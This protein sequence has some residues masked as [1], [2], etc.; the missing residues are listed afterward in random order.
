MTVRILRDIEEAISRE[1]RRITFH[2][3]RTVDHVVLKEAFDPFTG[4]LV[5]MPVEADFYDSSANANNI[6]YPHF[7]VKLLKIKEDLTTG[8]VIPQYGKTEL[9]PVTTSAKAYEVV[10]FSSDGSIAAPGNT[11]TTSNFKIRKAEPGFLIRL[12]TGNNIGAYRILSVTPSN[13]GPHTITVSPDLAVSLP[14]INFNS[15][16]RVITFLDYVDLNTVKAGDNFVDFASN[17]WAITAVSI[18]AKQITI[19]GIG[20]PDLSTGGKFSRIGDIFQLADPSIVTFSVMDPTKPASGVGIGQDS[21]GNYEQMQAVDPQVPLDIY[22]LVRIDSRERDTHIDVATRMWEEFNPPRTALPTIVRSKT[23]VEQKITANVTTGGSN[24]LTIASNSDININDRVFVFD[25]LTPTKAT[26]G[27]GFQSVLEA[28]VLN[29]VG[30]TQI[31]LS[32]NVPDTFLVENNTK[33]VTNAEYKQLMFHFVDHLT[34]DVEGAQY[35]VHEFTFWIQAWIDRQ[36]EA[37]NYDGVIQNIK[38]IGVNIDDPEI[39]E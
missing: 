17:T 29:K 14:A 30:T 15:T 11:I 4:E 32:Q 12:R 34:K 21:C 18:N 24:V 7:F 5:S 36:G 23:S 19:S 16:S 31:V 3:G 39:L 33:V 13:S 35:W 10:F 28:T 20:S 9:R 25:D 8:R 6:Q 1:V 26:D 27:K 37:T 22:Y 2:E 38:L